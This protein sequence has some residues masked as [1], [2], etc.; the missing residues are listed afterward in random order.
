MNGRLKVKKK[1]F[2]LYEICFLSLMAALVYIF[3]TYFKT[4]IGLSGHNGLFWVIPFI[5]GV[6]VTRKLG[7]SLYIGVLSGLLIGV[8]GMN[9]EGIFKVFEW[10]AMG[11]AIDLLAFVFKGHLGNVL[12]GFVIGAFGNLAKLPVNFAVASFLQINAN[13]ILLGLGLAA[14]SHLVFGGLGGVI[15]A[16]ILNRIQHLRFPKREH[17]KGK[18]GT[19]QLW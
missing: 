13:V 12:V 8:I 10:V 4:P 6:G 16:V 3:K 14:V 7:S 2:V 1:F 17:D 18:A 19:A 11:I 15:S 9:D 5:V